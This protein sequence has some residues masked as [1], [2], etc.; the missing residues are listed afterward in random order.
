MI[1][2]T[3][4]TARGRSRFGLVTD[5][6]RDIG[7]VLREF[8]RYKRGKISELFASEGNGQWAP[9]SERSEDRGWQRALERVRRAPQGLLRRLTRDYGRA[10]S[11][12]S[13][14]RTVSLIGG[15]TATVT[16]KSNAVARRGFVLKAF[17]KILEGGDIAELRR[18]ESP[19][20]RLQKSVR[21]LEA[22][23]GRETARAQRAGQLLAGVAATIRSE[24][25]GGTMTIDSAWDSPAV[26]ALHDGATV[27]RGAVLPP[28]P[29]LEWDDSDVEFFRV[30]L[31]QRA[32]LAWG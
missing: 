21:G 28:R 24:I 20:R 23:L 16:G 2:L 6:L 19:D 12:A 7:P 18:F 14:P 3:I 4:D 29:F 25:R 8:D 11:R 30:L 13:A 31:R 1:T 22:R 17:E 5:A 15:M 27:G 9:R 32:L 26:A 10:L